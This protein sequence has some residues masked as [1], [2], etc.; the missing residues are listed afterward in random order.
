MSEIYQGILDRAIQRNTSRT[1]LKG[2]YKFTAEHDDLVRDVVRNYYRREGIL[3]QFEIF[4][5]LLAD[6]GMNEMS[7]GSFKARATA[8]KKEIGETRKAI[9]RPSKLGVEATEFLNSLLQGNPHIS[10]QHAFANL[11]LHLAS[12]RE[13]VPPIADVKS[14]LKYR[15]SILRFSIKDRT[16]I[17]ETVEL[18]SKNKRQKVNQDGAGNE[19][20]LAISE[21][22]EEVGPATEC[23]PSREKTFDPQLV[24]VGMLTESLPY[25]ILLEKAKK[26]MAETPPQTNLK[27]SLKYTS[28]HDDLIMDVV[29]SF[30]RD[31]SLPKQ[32]EVFKSLVKDLDMLE[33]PKGTFLDRAYAIRRRIWGY[34]RDFASRPTVTAKVLKSG[35][36]DLFFLQ[37]A[38]KR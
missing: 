19:V 17:M 7:I 15:K 11:E 24:N 29:K 25:K 14:W 33:M 34:C 4:S 32:Y 37:H 35:P 8:A 16:R 26:R 31:E 28:S 9:S 22:P 23:V 1:F 10:A 12:V 3:R 21:D 27:R 36:T 5:Q 2:S 20:G 6:L 30:K 13:P 18:G 38:K